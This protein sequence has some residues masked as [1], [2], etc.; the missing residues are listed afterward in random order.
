MF[1]KQL[2]QIQYNKVIN[3]F[4]YYIQTTK[5]LKQVSVLGPLI[6]LIYINDLPCYVKSFIK[7]FADDVKIIANV[8]FY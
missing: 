3:T 1:T 8:E 4:N 2:L 7:L 5:F 6:F